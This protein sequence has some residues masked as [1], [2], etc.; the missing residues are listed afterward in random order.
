M[1]LWLMQSCQ[2]HLT[3]I[4]R[5]VPKTELCRPHLNRLVMDYRARTEMIWQQCT[6]EA[7]KR[8]GHVPLEPEKP[9]R[10]E[11][12][13]PSTVEGPKMTLA[14]VEGTQRKANRRGKGTSTSKWREAVRFSSLTLR[15]GSACPVWMHKLAATALEFPLPWA[16]RF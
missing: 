12:A 14:K 11:C 3:E 2:W 16:G 10:S 13:V 15:C 9:Q 6:E 7:L 1:L 5:T 4:R 8:L